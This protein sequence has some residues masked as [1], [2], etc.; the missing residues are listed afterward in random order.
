MLKGRKQTERTVWVEYKDGFELEVRYSNRD[1]AREFLTRCTIQ[2]WD[3]AT[4][5]FREKVD[6]KKYARLLAEEVIANWRGL[7]P[8]VLKQMV[9]L[10]EYPEIEVPFSVDDAEWLLNEA[11]GF[12][13]WVQQVS[14]EIAIFNAVRRSE[15]VKNS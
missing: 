13:L 8:P 3:V 1:R 4:R 7:T 12:D 11:A 15:E 6:N 10:D 14:H 9:L 5:Q 2:E